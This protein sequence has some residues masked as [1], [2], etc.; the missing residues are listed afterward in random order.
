[1]TQLETWFDD[2]RRTLK[3]RSL[4]INQGEDPI[5]FLVYP[6]DRSL[7]IYRALPDLRS[8]L[9]HDQ[10]Q[11]RT[12]DLG[13]AVEAFI[14]GHRDYPL[15]ADFL[16]DNPDR[17]DAANK[18]LSDFL[19]RSVEETFL[20]EW[21]AAE[22]DAV[23][24]DAAERREGALLLVVGL[25]LLHPYIQIGRIE[26]KLQGRV[27]CPVVVLYPGTRTGSFGLKY[28]GFYKADGNYRSRHVGGTAS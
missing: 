20:E 6:P 11:P 22:I 19:N 18:S 13:A 9:I 26:Q 25:E 24:I 1:M 3:H 14:T 16:R 8:K 2:L 23:E 4:L 5:F 15:V 12:Y 21:L 10:W 28:L 17:L 27:R 7:E